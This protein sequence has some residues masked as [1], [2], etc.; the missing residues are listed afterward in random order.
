[1]PRSPAILAHRIQKVAL[2]RAVFRKQAAKRENC[3]GAALETSPMTEQT[4]GQ[5]FAICFL[6]NDLRFRLCFGRRKR[7]VWRQTPDVF[8]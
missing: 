4:E 1:M 6:F 3:H 5:V 8:M 2:G 7:E